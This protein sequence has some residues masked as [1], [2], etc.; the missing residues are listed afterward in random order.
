MAKRLNFKKAEGKGG[1]V[2]LILVLLN[3]FDLDIRME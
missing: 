2:L 1:F 3:N